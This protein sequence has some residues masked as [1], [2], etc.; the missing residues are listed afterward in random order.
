MARI[1]L[2]SACLM[3]VFMTLVILAVVSLASNFL[4][5]VMAGLSCIMIHSSQQDLVHPEL[6]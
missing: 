6:E 4:D 1:A 5:F 3:P 2:A